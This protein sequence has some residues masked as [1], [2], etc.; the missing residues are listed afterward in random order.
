LGAVESEKKTTGENELLT[1]IGCKDRVGKT[2]TL[3]KLKVGDATRGL[4]K[5]WKKPG[6]TQLQ[7]TPSIQT[8]KHNI[9]VWVGGGGQDGMRSSHFRRQPAQKTWECK[10]NKQHGGKK[11]TKG[12]KETP[13]HPIQPRHL[14]KRKSAQ[15]RKDD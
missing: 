7:G 10:I 15:G 8:T 13:Q 4:T 3:E 2:K 9:N 12:P 11:S 14:G 6:C 1:P 5:K